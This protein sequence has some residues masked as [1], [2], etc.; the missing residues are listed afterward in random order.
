[1][2]LLPDEEN[3]R[4]GHDS[5]SSAAEFS[6]TAECSVLAASNSAWKLVW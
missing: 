5:G 2:G 6:T 3:T 4:L 1:M